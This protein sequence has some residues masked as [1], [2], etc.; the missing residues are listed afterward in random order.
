MKAARRLDAASVIINDHTAFRA[1][2]MPFGG[3][4][5]SGLGQGGLGG[6]LREMSS[7]KL[8]VMPYP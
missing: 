1:D 5:V 2:W 7:E 3:R 4:G 8:I 6:S